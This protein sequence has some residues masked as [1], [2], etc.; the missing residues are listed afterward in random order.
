[1]ISRPGLSL[2]ITKLLSEKFPVGNLFENK[3]PL[4]ESGS[5][6]SYPIFCYF[7]IMKKQTLL[8][9]FVLGFAV[10]AIFFGAGNL[11]FPPY[12]GLES[13]K[14]WF[15]GF[16]AFSV[17]DIGMAVAT[18]IAIIKNG[19]D[20]SAVFSHLGRKAAVIL[21]GVAIICV[22]P[23]IAI[24]RT[25]ATTFDMSITVLLPGFPMVLF[26]ILFFAVTCVLS[27][28]P[29]SIVDIIGKFFA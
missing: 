8:K 16:L 22:G 11:I 20:T 25:C 23:L 15:S 2:N 19:G 7:S 10:F 27:L 3:F 26:T 1:M 6:E 29:S 21:S 17:V 13:G 24:P 18:V 5:F 28:K 14:S 12:L 9:A 4:T